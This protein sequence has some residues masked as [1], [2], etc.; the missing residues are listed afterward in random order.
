MVEIKKDEK[1][2]LIAEYEG[3]DYK[4]IPRNRKMPSFI[5]QNEDG[6]Y[7]VQTKEGDFTLKELSG[8]KLDSARRIAAQIG[9]SEEPVIAAKSIVKPQ[10]DQSEFF[11]LPGSVYMKLTGAIQYI[12]ELTDFLE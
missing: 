12:Y 1:G 7:T 9:K 5:I 4:L 6:T 8:E 11:D 10:L 2:Q 3:I